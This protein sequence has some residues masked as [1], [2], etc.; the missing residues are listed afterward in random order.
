ME[1]PAIGDLI[2]IV[3]YIS[4]ETPDATFALM[5]KKQG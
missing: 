5:K 1:G 2:A 4:D 3:D